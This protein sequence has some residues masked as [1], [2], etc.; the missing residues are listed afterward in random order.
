M[1]EPQQ[2]ALPKQLSS[3]TLAPGFLDIIHCL[4]Q[5]LT[6]L[7]G[8][9]ELGLL[10]EGSVADYRSALNEGLAQADSLARLLDSLRE[11][12]EAEEATD[13]VERVL[14]EQLIKEADSEMR[15]LADFRRLNLAF[16]FKGSFPVRANLRRLRQAVYKVIHQAIQRTPALGTVLVSLSTSGCNACLTVT[17]QGPAHRQGEL[18]HLSLATSLGELF[19]EA[20]KNGTLEWA[21][22][23]RIFEVQGGGVRVES[24]PQG[25]CC[26][27]ASLP[28]APA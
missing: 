4:S 20:L 25:G 15:L 26:F 24:L 10:T 28:L 11:L 9:L 2:T 7:R 16:N 8:S 18:E 3:S 14:L 22:A 21:I 13:T 23:K 27:D 5:P 12:V 17:D 19:S 1:T 6:A